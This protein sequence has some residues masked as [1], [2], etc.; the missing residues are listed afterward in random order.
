METQPV[1]K[2]NN[3]EEESYVENKPILSSLPLQI[4]IFFDHYYIIVF[5]LVFIGLIIYKSI[6]YKSNYSHKERTLD[7]F[8]LLFWIICNKARLLFATM[9]N[10][11]EKWYP[12]FINLVLCI[13]VVL[14]NVF[15]YDWQTHVILIDKIL[16]I[17]SIIFISLE[18]LLSIIAILTFISNKRLSN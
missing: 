4:V 9:G 5:V 1:T 3:D 16:S 17:G 7:V 2:G 15:F 14:G 12:I 11:L 8:I 13:P 10:K 6:H 18:F